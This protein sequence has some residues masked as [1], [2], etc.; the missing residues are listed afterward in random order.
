MYLKHALLRYFKRFGTVGKI[1]KHENK[2]A[3]ACNMTRFY[4]IFWLAGKQMKAMKVN[5]AFWRFY[6]RRLLGDLIVLFIKNEWFKIHFCYASVMML[7]QFVYSCHLNRGQYGFTI[8]Q[9]MSIN[10]R[11]GYIKI[12][13]TIWNQPLGN[14]KVL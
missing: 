8:H 2:D 12:P 3:Y 5:G 6:A 1:W 7:P 11:K 4:T 13:D 14:V 9:T 10:Q